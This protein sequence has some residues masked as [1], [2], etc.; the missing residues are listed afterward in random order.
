MSQKN[1]RSCLYC[2]STING[3]RVDAVYCGKLCRT[4]ATKRRTKVSEGNFVQGDS[5]KCVECNGQFLPRF[6]RHVYCSK[7][8][9]KTAYRRRINTGRSPRKCLI[10]NHEFLP[11][12]SMHR[13]CSDE[14][15]RTR[16]RHQRL[17]IQYGFSVDDFDNLIK[18]QGGG[19]AICQTRN[20]NQWAVDHDHNCC[21]SSTVT[22]GKCV[23]GVLCFPCN[24]ALGLFKDSRSVL[25]KALSYL[26]VS[27]E[28]GQLGSRYQ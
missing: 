11:N 23:R 2:G 26:E 17:A 24:Q 18:E 27:N 14:C 3:L 7:S 12:S 19:C 5:L 8:C 6:Q 25:K 20:A 9:E 22:C 16:K 13:M 15:L 4:Y 1:L 21:P 28:P 10:C